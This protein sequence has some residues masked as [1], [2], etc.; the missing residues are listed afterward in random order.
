[1]TVGQLKDLLDVYD[2]ALEI[3]NLIRVDGEEYCL[4]IKGIGS[5]EDEDSLYI[6]SKDE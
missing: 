4:D 5:F 6:F 2:D 1:M 3:C